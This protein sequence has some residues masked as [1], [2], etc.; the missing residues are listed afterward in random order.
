MK[1]LP[2]K[3]VERVKEFENGDVS[4]NINCKENV[5]IYFVAN[6]IIDE[7]KKISVLLSSSEHKTFSFIRDIIVPD[8]LQEITYSI[9]LA[10]AKAYFASVPSEIVEQF[11]FHKRL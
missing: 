7:R 2:R 3:A 1:C 9:P 5:D 4:W 6:K 8:T 11:K 10:K